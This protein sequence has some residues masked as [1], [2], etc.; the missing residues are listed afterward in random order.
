MNP[1]Q[2]TSRTSMIH[3]H[4][5][6]WPSADDGFFPV[7]IIGCVYIVRLVLHTISVKARKTRNRRL[8]SL[9]KLARQSTRISSWLLS[10]ALFNI[11]IARM[12]EQV[13]DWW[14]ERNCILCYF[15]NMKRPKWN[16]ARKEWDIH[17]ENEFFVWFTSI[18]RRSMGWRI[19]KSFPQFFVRLICRPDSQSK[20][21]HSHGN[22][23]C[24]TPPFVMQK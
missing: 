1:W 18:C 17:P 2:E 19:E 16:K 3:V 9:Y 11:E 5:H 12:H 6:K 23:A 8:F 7:Y 13:V 24:L 21:A 14:I 10:Q 15:Y 20:C 22:D 4:G